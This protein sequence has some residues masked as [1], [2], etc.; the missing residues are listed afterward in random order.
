MEI[1]N[2]LTIGEVLSDDETVNEV[3]VIAEAD[4]QASSGIYTS[5]TKGAIACK[6]LRNRQ[7]DSFNSWLA[8]QQRYVGIPG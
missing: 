2:D 7:A 6:G 3:N 4:T 5:I 1:Q 8:T